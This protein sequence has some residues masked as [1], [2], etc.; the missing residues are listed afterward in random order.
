MNFMEKADI[1]TV[2]R[3]KCGIAGCMCA[4]TRFADTLQR[5]L[6]RPQIF[7]KLCFPT[8]E[9]QADLFQKLKRKEPQLYRSLDCNRR[10]I[11]VRESG[12]SVFPAI[13]KRCCKED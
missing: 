13:E 3:Q 9:Q 8:P 7:E 1:G 4:T 2:D 11:F 6:Q 5:L 12:V 10:T